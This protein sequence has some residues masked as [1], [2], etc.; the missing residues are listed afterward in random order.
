MTELQHEETGNLIRGVL[1]ATQP[2]QIQ[3]VADGMTELMQ[4]E[5]HR[6][7]DDHLGAGGSPGIDPG[8]DTVNL[9]GSS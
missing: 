8:V 2:W 9:R 4:Y 5:G 6:S 3:I 1:L 7:T